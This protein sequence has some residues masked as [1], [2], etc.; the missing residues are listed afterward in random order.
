[1]TLD[2]KEA[3]MARKALRM[4]ARRRGDPFQTLGDLRKGAPKIER[5]GDDGK[6]Y[7]AGMGRELDDFRL[8]NYDES[9]EQ[10]IGFVKSIGTPDKDK[11]GFYT[12]NHIPF[13][14]PYATVNENLIVYN[15]CYKGGI[16]IHRCTPDEDRLVV[17]ALDP[18]TFA[19]VVIDGR[20]VKTG[21][22]VRCNDKPIYSYTGKK[23]VT[24]VYCSPV[25][26]MKVMLRGQG[27][28]ATWDVLSTSGI[29]GEHLQQQLET[30]YTAFASNP[31]LRDNGLRGIPFILHRTPPQEIPY[32]DDNGKRHTSK[33][34]L[35]SIEIAPDFGALFMES[36]VRYALQAVEPMKALKQGDNGVQ[37]QDN[38]DLLDQSS[39][40][41]IVENEAPEKTD[42]A[43]TNVA[44]DEG[45]KWQAA[46]E[47]LGL[48]KPRQ[49]AMIKRCNGDYK[50]AYELATK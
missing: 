1:M 15:E 28:I 33:H 22:I 39:G 20:D 41:V 10:L 7:T 30:F 49:D 13:V 40:G 43:D 2:C 26:R 32:Y 38:D 25:I 34:S 23:G 29:D 36:S 21:E 17:R 3:S 50:A 12:V 45:A 4:G 42:G 9:D 31:V 14:F 46:F 5:I 47:G 18:V 11:R 27:R 8:C 37:W 44:D 35:I 24:E 16:M 19:P 6:P 48:S